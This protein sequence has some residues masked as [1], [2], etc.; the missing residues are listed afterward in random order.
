[1]IGETDDYMAAIE[2]RVKN[3][4][5]DVTGLREANAVTGVRL[6]NGVKVFAKFEERITGVEHRT[7]PK[8]PSIIKIVGITLAVVMSGAGALWA[9]ANNLRD[10]PTVEQM[11]KVM[12]RRDKG[13]EHAGHKDIRVTVDSIQKEQGA[14]RIL[15]DHS[16]R[17]Q[18]R[19][20]KKLDAPI[21][22]LP[23]K[24]NRG[25]R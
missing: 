14:Q 23:A 22:R 16:I 9:L 20:T 19:D 5:G 6:E 17:Q 10:R 11:E 7:S 4:E 25:R 18:D 2:E 12:E 13:H 1:M 8:P 21:Q 3:L 15:I 24:N